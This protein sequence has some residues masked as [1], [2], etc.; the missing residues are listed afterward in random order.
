MEE[1]RQLG[2][3]R[4]SSASNSTLDS[5]GAESS[6][7]EI[8]SNQSEAQNASRSQTPVNSSNAN[9]A[10]EQT[11]FYGGYG[12]GS[13]NWGDHSNYVHANNMQIVSPIYNENSSLLF[14]PVYGFDPQVAYSPFSPIMID[15]QLYSPQQVPVSPS[16]Y[17]QPISPTGFATSAGSG[18]E[19]LGENVFWGY[20]HYPMSNGIGFYNGSG[21]S[22]S[23][24]S[25]PVGILGPYEHSFGQTPYHMYDA[26]RLNHHGLDKEVKHRDRD[27]VNL[28][29]DSH[30]AADKNRGPRASK[31]KGSSSADHT[32]N[33]IDLYNRADFV[34]TYEKAKFFVIKS[35]SE[36]NVH[37]SIKYGV[38]ASTPLGNRKLDAAYKEAKKDGDACPVFLFFS[39]NAS[40]QFCGVAEMIGPVDFENDADHWQL[41]RWS[42]QFR[43]QWHI[44]KDVPNSRFRHLLLENNEHKPVTH[45]RDSQEVPHEEGIAM[46]KIFKE[47]D[48]GTSILDDFC[49]YDDR[50][51]SFQDNKAKERVSSTKNSVD[52][53]SINQLSDRVADSLRLETNK[54]V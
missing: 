19:G 11:Y 51:K 36:D 9:A 39:V 54:E 45:S 47:H 42:G 35:F 34:T 3:D 40:G 1:S 52:D 26:S 20:V 5:H 4:S 17:S 14:H 53:A 29:N 8:V 18:Q 25:T 44:I 10:S 49:F 23:N 13:V 28:T 24:Q 2:Q 37:R 21:E 38:W 6:K 30:V 16:Y 33:H 31:P 15:G 48:S 27:S 41:D 12:D 50:E 43:V 32:S 7:D 22:V 46:L